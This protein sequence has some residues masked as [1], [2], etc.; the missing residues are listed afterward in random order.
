MSYNSITQRA[1]AQKEKVF[2]KKIYMKSVL[3]TALVIG[4][5]TVM[6]CQKSS[7]PDPQAAQSLDTS[8]WKSSEVAERSDS[9]RGKIPTKTFLK[10]RTSNPDEEIYYYTLI[11][12]PEAK[13][14]DKSYP[15]Y[16]SSEYLDSELSIQTYSKNFE[17]TQLVLTKQ[18]SIP[19]KF[20]AIEQ[21]NGDKKIYLYATNE[22]VSLFGAYYSKIFDLSTIK[23]DQLLIEFFYLKE[24]NQKSAA[25]E[26]PSFGAD[27]I[28]LPAIECVRGL[29]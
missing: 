15:K 9:S 8:T 16:T 11:A 29:E 3:L 12:N 22:A 10:C 27:V 1:K 2:M 14:V 13:K 26:F 18:I 28:N 7:N 6:S 23:A 25:T 19:V 24:N 4:S 17:G 21:D 20:D 5:L